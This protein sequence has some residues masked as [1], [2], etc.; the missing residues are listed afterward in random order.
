[1]S[2]VDKETREAL[3]GDPE[4]IAVAELVASSL[5]SPRRVPAG[6]LGVALVVI[7]LCAAALL[8]FLGA[9]RRLAGP[10]RARPVLHGGEAE[11]ELI[12]RRAILRLARG[13]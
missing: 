13:R 11:L 12:G 8:A 7:L 2:G 3:A 10:R 4:L 6:R 5:P 9:R 1:V